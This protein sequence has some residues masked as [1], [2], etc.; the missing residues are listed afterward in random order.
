MS[1]PA[2]FKN[3]KYMNLTTYRKGGEAMV[4]TVLF[5]IESEN[6]LVH[7]GA[8]SGKVRRIRNNK[9]VLVQPSDIFGKPLG[10]QYKAEAIVLYGEERAKEIK[11]VS[12]CCFEKW[13]SYLFHDAILRLPSDVLRIKIR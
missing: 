5:A 1:V 9:N 6:I 3:R 10:K 2:E 13:V 12:R 7:T 8:N 4:T 11:V